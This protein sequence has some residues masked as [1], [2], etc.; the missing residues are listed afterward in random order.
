MT[1]RDSKSQRVWT[2]AETKAR[3]SE[4]LRLAEEEGPQQIGKRKSFVVVPAHVWDRKKPQCKPMGR[5][6]VDHMPR[7]VE[8]EIPDR[9][10]PER[11]IPFM[12]KEDE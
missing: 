7:G 12:T 4:V 2:V 8:L 6:L 3:Q 1:T 9:R 10:E 5:W 11:E